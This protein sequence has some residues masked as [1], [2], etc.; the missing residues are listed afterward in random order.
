MSNLARLSLASFLAYFVMSGMLA[1]IGIVSAPMAEYFGVSV[2]TATA[3]F[4][5]LTVGIWIGA[6][7]ALFVFARVGLR[8][9]M[10][11][12]YALLA[13]SLLTLVMAEGLLAVGLRLGIVGF[14]CGVGLP[15]AA[16]VI[17]RSYSDS[18]RA[19][20]LVITDGSFSFA[21]IV[22]AWLAV[23]FIDGG[24]AWYGAYLFVAV[25][26]LAVVAL[27]VFASFPETV[28]EHTSLLEARTWPPAAWLCVICLGLYTVGQNSI[29][30]WLPRYAEDTLGASAEFA[31][32]LVGQYWSGMFAAQLFVAWWVLKIGV[33]RLLLLGALTT[34]LLSTPFW[35]L[36]EPGP[37]MWLAA[38]WGFANL[39]L[40]K[41]ILSYATELA[42]ASSSQLV[43]ALLLGATSGTAV[44][45]WLSS[46]IVAAGSS[47]DALIFGSACFLLMFALLGVAVFASRRVPEQGSES[48]HDA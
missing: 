23:W 9:L 47:A 21:G 45:P 20:M 33:R 11:S 6:V 41:I 46:Q 16:L 7:T 37:F 42:R 12:L 14:C 3:R 28:D 31:G 4:S 36:A 2:T 19:S 27:S 26:A 32:Q 18:R 13:A 38:A 35:W 24:V 17:A 34:L 44:S 10:I 30:W 40:L 25:M 8:A 29:L 39:G 48:A 5:W 1:P 15:A 22:T 43:S